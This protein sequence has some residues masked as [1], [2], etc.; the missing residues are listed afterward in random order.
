V[1]GFGI[2]QKYG[3]FILGKL[4]T[5][6]KIPSKLKTRKDDIVLLDNTNSRVNEHIIKFFKDK[7]KGIKS[8]DYRIWARSYVKHKGNAQK[9][10]LV[11]ELLNRLRNPY[12]VA[13]ARTVC[14]QT[15]TGKGCEAALAA[16][17]R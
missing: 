11:Q 6:F 8:L 4:R 1:H 17:C 13:A 2:T 16:S 15:R 12:R 14:W 3:S 10:K 7:C 5:Y 9:L